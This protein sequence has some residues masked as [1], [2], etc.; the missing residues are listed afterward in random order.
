LVRKGLLGRYAAGEQHF[1]F[2]VEGL[3]TELPFFFR[4]KVGFD[5]LLRTGFSVEGTQNLAQ[6]DHVDVLFDGRADLVLAMRDEQGNGCLQV[7]DLKTKG[8]RDEFNSENPESGSRLQRYKGDVLVPY[9]STLEERSIL[10]EHRLQLT[11]YSM[12]LEVLEQQKPASERRRVLPPALLI[13]ASGRMVQL[14]Q[15]EYES[16]SQTLAQHLEWMAQ[17][18][19]TPEAVSEPPRLPEDSSHICSQCPFGRGQIRLCGPEGSVLGPV[20]DDDD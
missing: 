2:K 13:G 8:C 3:R 9:P 18:S 7:V 16:A 17:L 6:I 5:G 20:G 15:N 1:G 10:D 4:H 14:T 12:A 11:L 19:A